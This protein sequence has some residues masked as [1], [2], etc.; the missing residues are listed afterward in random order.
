M[1]CELVSGITGTRANCSIDGRG[2]SQY[3]ISYQPTVKG[4]GRHQ[5]HIKVESQYIRGSLFSIAVK[6]PVEKLGTQIHTMDRPSGVAISQR[7]EVVV[8]EKRHCVSVLSSSGEKIRSFGTHGSGQGQFVNPQ[9]VAVGGE[10]NIFVADHSNHHLQ[11]FTAKGQFLA[12]MGCKG[13]GPLQFSFPIGIATN[14]IV[15]IRCMW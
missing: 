1:E 12:A 13:N 9:G 15:I 3:Q 14:P 8:T 5:L 4:T 11:K 6:S 7:G 10:E 2:Q